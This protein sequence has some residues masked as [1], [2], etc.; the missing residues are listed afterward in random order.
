[1]HWLSC[2]RRLQVSIKFCIIHCM[3]IAQAMTTTTIFTILF[4]T[5]VGMTVSAQ[6]LVTPVVI[7]GEGRAV[8]P[9]NAQREAA[10]LALHAEFI[11][12]FLPQ[13]GTGSW[14]RIGFLNMSNSTQQCPSSFTMYTDPRSC[15]GPISRPGCVA[16]FLSSGDIEYNRVCGRIIGYQHGT[17]D[18]F[19]I[20]LSHNG[21]DGSS[22]NDVYVDG[23]SLT[24]GEPRQHIWTFAAGS[25]EL[26]DI[27]GCYC[28]G[29]SSG[30]LP[31]PAFVGNNYF[32][33]SAREGL[34]YHGGFYDVN[35]LL[36]DGLA[37]E[38]T[39]CC[40]FNTPPWF[41]VQLPTPT[42]DNIE[43]R[44]C[45]DEGGEDVLIQLMEIYVL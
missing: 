2:A 15:G 36:W 39:N 29:S 11:T 13:C 3:L 43:L 5:R 17:T 35:D 22:I 27:Y 28:N 9:S 34:G 18:G 32:C 6:R 42:T 20:D 12:S 45:L 38:V 8:C 37:C 23:V 31:P 10:R 1:M 21:V 33:E 16:N 24:H 30:A 19:N 40:E 25:N 14:R 7:P 41:M 26:G 4:L 44:I